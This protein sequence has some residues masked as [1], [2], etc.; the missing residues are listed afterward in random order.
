M[1][2]KTKKIQLPKSVLEMKFMKKTRERIE[3]EMENMQD[4]GSLYSN[5]ITNEMRSASGNFI[6]ES[7]FIFCDT[8]LEGRLS[9]K[10]MNPEIERLMELEN[11]D[12]NEQPSSEMVKDV[13][14]EILAKK[15]E[16]FNKKRQ[17][18]DSEARHNKRKKVNN[19]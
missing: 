15:M 8:M 4:H 14:D 5:I 16:K 13:S 9:F 10:G 6:S 7:S 12:K 2:G 11:A 19:M 3:K 18:P 17:N 1:A